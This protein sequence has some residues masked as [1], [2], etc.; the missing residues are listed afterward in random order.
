[1][2]RHKKE[3]IEIVTAEDLLAKMRA[4]TREVH[5]IRMREL[6]IPVRVLSITEMNDIRRDA[7][8]SAIASQGDEVDKNVITQ[9]STLKLATNVVKG[10]AP[11]LSD[12]V[13]SLMSVDEINYLYNEYVRVCESVNPSVESIEPEQFRALV[14]A[15]KKNTITSKDCS[16]VQLRA[17]CTSYVDTIQ[18]QEHQA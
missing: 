17:I 15:L 10:G 7:L 6:V 4:G 8:R 18:R 2:S 11:F 3:D 16:L 12:K 13:L 14:D 5:E 9:K 1:M